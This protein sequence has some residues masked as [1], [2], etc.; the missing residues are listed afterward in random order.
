MGGERGGVNS[1][2]GPRPGRD[3]LIA[4]M[5]CHNQFALS[6]QTHRRGSGQASPKSQAQKQ[7]RHLAAHGSVPSKITVPQA[8]PVSG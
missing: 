2:S 4:G 8:E 5:L 3:R 6:R 1:E 7:R